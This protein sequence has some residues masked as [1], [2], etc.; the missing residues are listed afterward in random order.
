MHKIYSIHSMFNFGAVSSLRTSECQQAH[1]FITLSASVV[2]VH[3]LKQIMKTK[4]L[5]YVSETSIHVHFIF[6]WQEYVSCNACI[7]RILT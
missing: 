7:F 2:H 5:R 3:N 6:V 4:D 1:Y